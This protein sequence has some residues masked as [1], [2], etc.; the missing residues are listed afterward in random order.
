MI[1][2]CEP[3]LARW[4]PIFGVFSCCLF[5]PF[6]FLLL[7]FLTKKDIDEKMKGIIYAMTVVGPR[8]QLFTQQ[9]G[10]KC[11]IKRCIC[12]LCWIAG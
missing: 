8:A 10:L 5:N 6:F 9:A 7:L 4:R 3:L 12:V 2:G 1:N 11:A